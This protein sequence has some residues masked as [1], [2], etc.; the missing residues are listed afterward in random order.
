M[1]HLLF[2]VIKRCG[3]EL[4]FQFE[5]AVYFVRCHQSVLNVDNVCMYSFTVYCCTLCAKGV[6]FIYACVFI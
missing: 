3:G 4:P 5:N 2:G 1:H 6:V